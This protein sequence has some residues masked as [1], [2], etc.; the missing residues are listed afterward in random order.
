MQAKI[1]DC[2]MLFAEVVESG[3]FTAAAD[4]LG[5]SKG[6]VSQKVSALEKEL[7]VQLLLRTTRRIKVTSAGEILLQQIPKLNDFWY[8]TQSKI[9]STKEEASGKLRITAP[10]SLSEY[11]LVP[12]LE[13][14]L[15]LYPK[16]SIELDTGN[17]LIDQVQAGF[18]LAVRITETPPEH[19]IARELL[20]V[21]YFCCATPEYLQKFGVPETPE[22]LHNHLCLSLN[23]WNTWRFYDAQKSYIVNVKSR[24]QANS[25]N[26]LKNSALNHRGII[27]LP[28]YIIE[29]ELDDGRLVPVLSDF[30]H[31]Q[32][33]VYLLYPPMKK[34]P[35]KALSCIDFLLSAFNRKT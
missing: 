24:L 2:V 10:T 35:Q 7:D 20:R 30:Q 14:F 8:E 9:Q 28:H 21:Q 23:T 19:L 4:K 25:N 13:Q 16:T 3:S 32:K 11:I 26:I 6:Y 5:V 18:D 22:D 17:V 33:T 12:H 15:D 31:E 1:I 27:R 34:R 29:K